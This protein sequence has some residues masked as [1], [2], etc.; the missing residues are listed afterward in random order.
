MDLANGSC[1]APER[2]DDELGVLR[3]VLDIVG[4]D[5]NVSEVERRIDLVHEVQ[6]CRLTG[7]KESHIA[8]NAI[9]SL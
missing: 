4:N 5:R 7:D 3:T 8:S 9:D 6:R 1:S 2:N